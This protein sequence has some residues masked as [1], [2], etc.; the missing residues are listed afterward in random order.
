MGI[1]NKKV[2]KAKNNA[3]KQIVGIVSIVIIYAFILHQNEG[4]YDV[5]GKAN[6][7]ECYTHSI[8]HTLLVSAAQLPASR[9]VMSMSV[10]REPRAST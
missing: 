1:F 3:Q 5:V 10:K 2:D 9:A 8:V 7:V 4:N 6:H